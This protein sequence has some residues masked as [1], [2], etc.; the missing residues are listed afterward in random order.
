[1]TAPARVAGAPWVVRRWP[2]V[3]GAVLA[4]SLAAALRF[5]VADPGDVADVLT[6]AGFVYLGA[7]ALRARAAAWPLIAATFVLIAV[8]LLVPEFHPTWWMAGIGA[9]LAVAGVIRGALRPAWGL[10]RQAL[11][12]VAVLA[13]AAAGAA[14]GRPWSALLVGAGLLGHAA[15]DVHHHRTGRVVPRS[16]AEFCAVLDAVLAVAVVALSLSSR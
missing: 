2:A 6:A 9:A 3:A 15:W 10:P 7:A 12:M 16:L 8:G 11:A 1:V 13:V 5:G 14:A 4:G